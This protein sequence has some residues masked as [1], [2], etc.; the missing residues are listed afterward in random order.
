MTTEIY[1]ITDAELEAAALKLIKALSDSYPEL[2]QKLG[3]VKLGNTGEF[4]GGKLH[5]EDQGE[6]RFA[7]CAQKGRVILEWGKNVS[8]IGLDPPTA[9]TLA[10]A[11]LDYAGRAERQ[12]G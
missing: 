4:P 8:W 7:I 2:F 9:R 11:F 10:A 12:E 1:G 3:Y 5:E 6:L